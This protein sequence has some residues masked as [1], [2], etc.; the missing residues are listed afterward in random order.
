MNHSESPFSKLGLRA[1]FLVWGTPGQGPR[2]RVMAQQ[3]GIESCFVHVR[4]PRGAWFAPLK[5]VLQAARTLL[6]LFRRRPQVVFVQSPPLFAV[7]CACLYCLLLRAHYIV[8]AHSAA[9]AGP[10]WTLP[11]RWLKSWLAR[12]ALTTIVTNDH[13]KQRVESLGG[14]ALIVRDVPLRLHVERDYPLDGAFNIALV[15]VFSPDE[16]LA[17]ALAAVADLAEVHLYVTGKSNGKHAQLIA[18]APANVRFTGFLPDDQ[19]YGLLNSVHAVMCLT[20]R[21]HTMQRGACEAL[22]LGK[23][24]ITSDWPVL[25]E[26]FCKGTVHVPNTGAGVRAG[27][28]KLRESYRQYQREIRDLQFMQGSEWREKMESIMERVQQVV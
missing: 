21:N 8:D 11:P 26:Y 16:P 9:F 3:L 7:L 17:E 20:T 14:R 2:S 27:V 19:Y 18:K 24:I 23:P 10:W 1:L 28:L 15:N 25:R 12:R 6:L 13:L 22:S 5:Y 4:L